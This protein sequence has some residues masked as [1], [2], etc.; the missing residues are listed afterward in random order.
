MGQYTHQ[1][2]DE[3]VD[4]MRFDRNIN[5]PKISI[6]IPIYNVEKY[7]NKCLDS[8]IN[9]TL[10]ELEFICINDGSTD[11]SINILNNYINNDSR[12]IIINQSNQGQGIARNN[13]IK[14]AKGEYIAFVDPDDW[15]EN[16]TFEKAYNLAIE[17]NANVVQ[18][19]YLEYNDI[20][21]TF[22]KIDFSERLKKQY[23]LDILK[24]NIYSKDDFKEGLFY[25]LDLHVWNR[26]YKR[27]FIISNQI[28]FAHTRNGEDHLFV[29]GVLLLS[30]NIHFL[31]EYLYIYR[32]REGSIV[33]TKTFMNGVYAFEDINCFKK[34]LES[35]NLFQK[36]EKDFYDYSMTIL[37]WHYHQLPAEYISEYEKQCEKFLSNEYYKKF[38]KLFNKKNKFIHKIFSLKNI[39]ENGEKIKILTILGIQIK[40]N[41]IG[42]NKYRR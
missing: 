5:K 21:K 34:F 35:K 40:F 28:E 15:L 12:F 8:L 25:N 9:Q 16:S 20:S 32:T 37:F 6:I 1:K 7:I 36:Y 14:I 22:K 18:F 11:N 38:K 4:T 13:G 26:I 24:S 41:K 33:N 23:K 29:N 39:K 30:D 19:N 27:D 42:K 3:Q 10:E 2:F 17:N 31:N